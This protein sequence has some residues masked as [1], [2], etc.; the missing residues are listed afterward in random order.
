MGKIYGCLNSGTDLF[1]INKSKAFSSLILLM[2]LF[3]QQS[4]F[5]DTNLVTISI[6]SGSNPMCDGSSVTF[7]A[8][9]SCA[10]SNVTY[11]WKVDGI[12]VPGETGNTFTSSI[13]NDGDVITCESSFTETATCI[14]SPSLSQEIILTVH[15]IPALSSSLTPPAICSGATFT[16]TPTSLTTGTTFTWTRSAVAGIT[17]SASTGTGS[18]SEILTN[19]TS[20]TIN[21]VYQIVSTANGCSGASENVTV[22][23][24]PKPVLSSSL[25]PPAICSGATF[26]NT[27]TSLT[28]GT[29]FTWT[30]SAVAG[31]TQSASTGTGSISEILTNTTTSTI[32]VVYQIV[33]TANGCSGAS[34][35]ITVAIYPRPALSSSLT[36]ASIC[37]ESTVSYTPS[38]STSGATFT[39]SRAAIP[40]ISESGTSAVGTINEVLTNTTASSITVT[41]NYVTTANGCSGATESVNI[42]V[43]PMPV[44]NSTLSPSA[45]CGGT[46]MSYIPSSLTASTSFNWSRAAVAGISQSAAS[47]SG[48]INETLTNTTVNSV[49][50]TY[51]FTLTSNGCSNPGQLVTV[52]VNPRPVLSSTLAPPAICSGTSFSYMPSSATSGSTFTWSRTAVSGI[53]QASATGTGNINEVL[54]NTTTTAKT[55]SYVFTTTANGCAGPAQIVTVTVKPTPNLSSTLSPASIC[56]GVNFS[57]TPSGTVASSSFTW[58]RAAITGISQAAASGSGSVSEVLTNTTPNPVTVTYIYTSTANGC[59]NNGQN[60]NVIIK[61]R[62]VLS[63]TLTPTGVCT[64]STFSY[65]ATSATAGTTFS[66]SKPAV[67][68]ITPGAM[69]GTGNVSMTLNNSTANPLIATYIYTLTAAGCTGTP[70]NVIVP[71]YPKP[72]VSNFSVPSATTVC[73]GSGSVVTIS[74]TSLS[75]DTYTVTYN[76]TDENVATG[77]TS[78]MVFTGNSATFTTSILNNTSNNGSTTV[79]VTAITNSYGCTSYVNKSADFNVDDMPSITNPDTISICSGTAV[80]KF[81]TTDYSNSTITWYALDSPDVTGESL[82][83]QTPANKKINDILVNQTLVDQ[84]VIY[85]VTPKSTNEGCSGPAKMITVT[86]KPAPT[87][88]SG[89]SAAICSGNSFSIPL[90]SDMPSTYQWIATNNL[91]TTGESLTL[92]TA[93]PISNTIT[94]NVASIQVINYTVNAIANINGCKGPSQNVAVTV[95]PKPVLTSVLTQNRCDDVTATYMASSATAG[96]TFSWERPLVTGISN[97]AA[98]GTGASIT[99]ALNNT[100]QLPVSVTYTI[101]LTA[102]GCSNSQTVNVTINPTPTLTGVAQQATVC[103]GSSATINLSGLL[104]N[105]TSSITYTINGGSTINVTNISSGAAGTGNFTTGN[106]TAGNNGQILQVTGITTTS[107]TPTCSQALT[108]SIPLS[109]TQLA[110]LNS[111]LTPP[112]ICSGNTFSYTPTS[113]TSGVTF[114]WIR[115]VLAGI[116][117]ASSSGTGPISETLTNTTTSPINVTYNITTINNGCSNIA[118]NVVVQVNPTC[119]V[120]PVADVQTCDGSVISA[121][122]FNGPVTGTTYTWTNTNTGIGLA[123]SGTGSIN[124]FTPTS[125]GLT[126][127]TIVVTPS[128]NGCTGTT[129]TFTITIRKAG[130]WIGVVSTDWFDPANWDCGMIPTSS[131]DATIPAT[132]PFMPVVDGTGAVCKDLSVNTGSSFCTATTNNIDIHGNWVNNGSCVHN[133]G[134]VTFKGPCTVLGGSNNNFHHVVITGTLTAPSSNIN[135]SGN[136][137]NNGTFNHNNGT[138]TFNGTSVQTIGGTQ[139]TTFKN[140]TTNSAGITLLKPTTIEGTLTLT[141]GEILTTMTNIL[142]LTNTAVTTIGH[143]GSFIQGPMKYIVATS[144]GNT[145]RNFPLGKGLDWRPAVLTVS[146]TN[147]TPVTYTGEVINQSADSLNYTLP[148]TINRV[149]NVR[150][151]QIDREN[152]ANFL[153]AKVQLYYGPNDGVT[154]INYVTTVKTIG[155]GTEWFDIGGTATANTTGSITS[156]YFTTFSKFTLGNLVGGT[157]PLPVELVEFTAAP[158]KDKVKLSWITASEVNNDFFTIE[159]SKDALT[160]E[161]VAR[162]KGSGTTNSMMEYDCL[163]EKPHPGTSYYRL[164]QTDFD[165]TTEYSELRSVNF[166]TKDNEVY[167][168]PNP[169]TQ[170]GFTIV[171]SNQE[172]RQ[173]SVTLVDATG[174]LVLSNDLSSGSGGMI[175]VMFD[176]ERQLAAGFYTLLLRDG[177]QFSSMKIVIQR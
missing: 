90:T 9:N 127:S 145:S 136:W 92:Q 28:T 38:S 138:V 23:V 36:P 10:D 51:S 3:L 101:D 117:Q 131:I 149:S 150:W 22:A 76:L 87:M 65:I 104:P 88:T 61:P 115:T 140:F 94:N 11:Q 4:L 144:T 34:E 114:T 148:P 30:R 175:Q 147:A 111:T 64:G 105:V 62:P 123:A 48:N 79:T 53:S 166:R 143:A 46:T 21:V 42:V 171:S 44:L 25:T 107:I 154:D 89:T 155:T 174:K 72:N 29:T 68:G 146:H 108:I 7:Q 133:T 168:Y 95:Y 6:V 57:Y 102:N 141:N 151:W 132:A 96:T 58:T 110:S 86:V 156:G 121:I 165:G 119:T 14:G 32:N 122:N 41:Y 129:E 109:V 160:F 60:V 43:K 120:S 35:N 40:G 128:A 1:S 73:A 112:A 142:T 153:M 157:N 124:S 66:W 97:P 126:T 52:T 159:K 83:P 93:N 2:L 152:I 85:Y 17:Q 49:V 18:I 20:A 19:T 169:A 45:I 77:N 56:S 27:P 50:V 170:E 81:I 103:P 162:V 176:A 47:S 12:D 31:I 8:T 98:S 78:T 63:S 106:L 74:S 163:D 125:T 164:K 173:V 39:W 24:Y 99:E 16:Y 59:S 118:Q 80:G 116:S 55:V 13:L 100:T 67:A 135:V 26:S 134:T 70:Q 137:S 130:S 54:T 5:A 158:S 69:T 113:A 172:I 139:S 71:V 15:P 37:S 167:V 91:N 84:T 82:T 75:D 177:N 161:E 33:S